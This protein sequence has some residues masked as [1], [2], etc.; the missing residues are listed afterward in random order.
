M[1][2]RGGVTAMTGILGLAMGFVL[3]QIGFGDYGELNAMFT[4]QNLRML[5]SFAGAVA[6]AGVLLAIALPRPVNLRRVNRGTIPGAVLF[7]VG[8][9]IC[10]GCPSIPIVQVASGYL[11]AL[12]TLVGIVLGMRLCRWVMINHWQFERDSCID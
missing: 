5:L 8:W 1:R 2:T 6:L 12:V 10:G 11:P 4:F 9:A 7:G 3:M